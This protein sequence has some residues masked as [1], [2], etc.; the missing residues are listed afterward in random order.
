MQSCDSAANTSAKPLHHW[1]HDNSFCLLVTEVR[2]KK[3]P[4]VTFFL[5]L[6]GVSVWLTVSGSHVFVVGVTR[7]RMVLPCV[8]TTVCYTVSG[9]TN[10]S[11]QV[12]RLSS[13]TALQVNEVREPQSTQSAPLSPT[14]TNRKAWAITP[15]RLSPSYSMF[16]YNK[17]ESSAPRHWEEKKQLWHPR[18]IRWHSLSGTH[19]SSQFWVFLNVVMMGELEDL[20]IMSHTWGRESKESNICGW[21]HSSL[22]LSKWLPVQKEHFELLLGYYMSPRGI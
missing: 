3:K 17:R 4:R 5:F 6:E 16:T 22:L 21:N 11:H 15:L 14:W 8:S 1:H 18:V 13:P 19:C 20:C 2:K 12:D 9:V 7:V 10:V